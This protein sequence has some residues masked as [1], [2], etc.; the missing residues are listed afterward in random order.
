MTMTQNTGRPLR[1]KVLIRYQVLFVA[2]ILFLAAPF[3][4][5]SHIEGLLAPLLFTLVALAALTTAAE[6]RGTLIVGLVLAVPSLLAGW[7]EPRETGWAIAGAIFQVAFPGWLIAGILSHVI[8][9]TRVGSDILFGVA[10]VYVLLAAIWAAGYGIADTLEHGDMRP[11]SDPARILAMLEATLG[12][13][14]LVI[15][16]AR[17]VGLHT[18]Q[19][20]GGGREADAPASG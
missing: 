15:V 19:A 9:A 16:V 3:V 7:L 13:L 6:S 11:V 4:V 2:L 12:Q 14:F 20:V 8:R 1:D 5:P 17:I 18:V 10:C